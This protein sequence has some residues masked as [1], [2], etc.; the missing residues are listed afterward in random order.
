MQQQL[1]SAHVDF[2]V[3][4]FVTDARKEYAAFSKPYHQCS[5]MGVA[6]PGPEVW[7]TKTIRAAEVRIVVAKNEVGFEYAR[8]ILGFS[9]ERHDPRF[10]VVE[11]SRIEEVASI[12]L[13]GGKNYLAI[14]DALSIHSIQRQ[15]PNEL[16][17]VL[18][19][20]ALQTYD[21]AVMFAKGQDKLKTWIEAEFD[22]AR[23]LPEIAKAED[24]L[25][26]E[27]HSH[28]FFRQIYWAEASA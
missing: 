5:M 6:H 20:P 24:E 1:E 18:N 8:S 12:V 11:T 7:D 19:D 10:T 25:M 3:C 9:P 22:R 14:A 13:G 21:L 15:H 16:R 28:G 26:A 27:L 23:L 17:V 2:I 4:A